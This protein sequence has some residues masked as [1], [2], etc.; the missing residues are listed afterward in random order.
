MR[1][2]DWAWRNVCTNTI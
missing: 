2:W 1:D